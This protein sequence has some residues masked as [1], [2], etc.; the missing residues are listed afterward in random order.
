M[1][2]MMLMLLFAAAVLRG[3]RAAGDAGDVSARRRTR[4]ARRRR[5]PRAATSST[6]TARRSRGRST[7][8]RSRST[9][10]KLIGDQTR[11]RARSSPTL[12]PERGDQAW[13][14]GQLTK[15]VSASPISSAAPSPALVEQ[16]N[17]LG[18]P[19]IVF[20]RET[21]AAVSAVDAG[22]ARARLPVDRRPRH[23]RDGARARRA[24]DRPGARA[25]SRSR[26]RSTRACRR[27]WR[28]SSA[29]RWPPIR[30]AARRA[31]CS[32]SH[33]GEVIAMVSLPIFN[34]NR[35]GMA[36]TEQLRNNDDAERLRAGLDVQAD[37]DGGGDRHRRGHRHGAPLRRDRAAAGRPLHDPRRSRDQKRWLNIPETLIHSS[38]IATA[39]IADE[40]GRGSGCRRCSASSAST[41][42][43]TSS[44]A[45]RAGRC[46]RPTGRGR[47]R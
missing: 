37:H 31:S 40:I 21:A 6:A 43:P 24:A 13:F 15:D 9:R 20:A 2:L 32:T 10:S 29:A 8:G 17:A 42:S 28:A 3:D 27:R 46:G 30:R 18:E 34:P 26:C 23:A 45:R 22:G 16:V 36:G 47:R 35:V 33:T 41:P 11:D 7:P 14:Y 44:C 4:G 5:W 1:R 19:A 39:R 38:N 12:M 25:A